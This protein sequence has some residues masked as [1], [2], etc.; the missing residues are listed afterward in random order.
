MLAK[1]ALVGFELVGRTNCQ[2]EWQV[3]DCRASN[4]PAARHGQLEYG[5]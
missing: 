1:V 3:L 4:L 2:S 5:G